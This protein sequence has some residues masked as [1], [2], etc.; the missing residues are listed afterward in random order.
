ME[1]CSFWSPV[2]LHFDSLKKVERH[3]MKETKTKKVDMTVF[4]KA[5]RKKLD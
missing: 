2:G 4:V 3:I 1:K 5:L